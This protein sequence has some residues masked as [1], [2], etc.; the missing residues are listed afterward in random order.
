MNPNI[1]KKC[2][3]ELSSEKPKLD[4]VRGMLEVLY[5]ICNNNTPKTV[6]KG[7]GL[8]ISDNNLTPVGSEGIIK[9]T[10]DRSSDL[11]TFSKGRVAEISRLSQASSE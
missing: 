10:D 1:L 3:E 6:L 8:N 7:P 5:D 9:N 4:Y 2:I 11:P